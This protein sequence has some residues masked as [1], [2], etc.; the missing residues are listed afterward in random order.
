MVS[1]LLFLSPHFVPLS[2][3]TVW[4]VSA[5]RERKQGNQRDDEVKREIAN[6]QAPRLG[7]TRLDVRILDDLYMHIPS[8]PPLEIERLQRQLKHI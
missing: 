1:L 5:N 4:C 7:L 3:H 6:D 2:P 8:S